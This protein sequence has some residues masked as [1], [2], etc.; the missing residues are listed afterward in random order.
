[1]RTFFILG[2][3]LATLTLAGCDLTKPPQGNND[4]VAVEMVTP[5]GGAFSHSQTADLSGYYLPVVPV[6]PDDFQL[7]SVFVGQAAEFGDW[8]AGKRSTTFAP[9]M[10]E[11]SVPGETTERVLPDSYAVSDGRIRMT[12]TSPGHGRVTFDARLDQGAL[13]TARRNLGE[14]EAPAMT[15]AITIGARSYTGIKFAWSGGD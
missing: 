11:F 5:R 2:P 9:V 14:G 8:E 6:G 7:S 12:G 13:S 3:A 1:M 15:A 10:L 4:D